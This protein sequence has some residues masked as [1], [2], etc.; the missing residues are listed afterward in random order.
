MGKTLEYLA[1]LS[2]EPAFVRETGKLQW[3]TA[4]GFVDAG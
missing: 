1:S 2:L 3:K 4:L